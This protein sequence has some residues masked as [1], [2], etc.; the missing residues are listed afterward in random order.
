MQTL[1]CFRV[2]ILAA[3][4]NPL[5]GMTFLPLRLDV[6]LPLH[7]GSAPKLILGL[8]DVATR[9]RLVRASLGA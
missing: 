6:L 2:A 8:H 9:F 3:V 7:Y 5:V 1:V 4:R